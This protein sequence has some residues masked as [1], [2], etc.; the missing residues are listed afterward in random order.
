MSK[1]VPLLII[2]CLPFL[3]LTQGA[4]PKWDID[5]AWGGDQDDYLMDI[6]QE[7][8]DYS[9]VS[10]GY[11][12]SSNNQDVSSGNKGYSDYWIVKSDTSGSIIYQR[13]F[14]ADSVDQLAV[15]VPVGYDAD[16]GY[17]LAGSS[18]SGQNGDKSED[19]KGG[20]DYWVI[21]IDPFG[22]KEWDKTIGG[23]GDDIL[24][25][26][27]IDANGNFILGGYSFSGVSGDK[28][29][30]NR[31]DEDYW[32]VKLDAS[33]NK[34]W[35]LTLGGD[36]SDILSNIT[37]RN[38]KIIVGG[39]SL[40][41]VSGDKS[42]DS[43]GGYDFWL[44]VLDFNGDILMDQTIG[45]NQDDFLEEIR[46]RAHVEGFWISGTT[47]SGST[48]NKNTNQ[49]GN[50]DAWVVVVDTLMN[51]SWD[52]TIGSGNSEVMKDMEIAP[53]G[54]A[55]LAG[56]GSG[57]GGNK[58]SSTNGSEDF[59]ICKLDTAGDF[60]WDKNYGGL[61]GDSIEAIFIKCDR[62]ILAGGF[63]V[64]DIS[65]DKTHANKGGVDYW[66]FELS[67]TTH[68]WFRTSNVC[69]RTP[70]NFFDESDTWPDQWQWDF[71]DPTSANNN[72][73]D[74]HP[75]H[76]YAEPG[77]YNVMMT[78][79]EGCQNDTSITKEVIVYE[80]TVLGNVDLGRDFS[81]CGSDSV[82]LI[83]KGDVP[84]RS[85]YVWS[86]GDSTENAWI[87]YR[88]TYT[89]TVTEGNC[90]ARDSVVVDTCPT[91]AVPNAFS[92]N[93]DDKNEVFKIPGVGFN[94]YELLIY[95]RWGQLIYRSTK[96]EE[97]W[98][99]RTMNGKPCQIDVYVYKLNFQ[100][101]GLTPTQKVGTIALIR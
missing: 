84:L 89:L 96:Q 97:G 48:G 69:A 67:I 44:N 52:K 4:F 95:N 16:Q 71:D 19:T 83:N 29:E 101:L 72:S 43:F 100:G 5:Y 92:P 53:D 64:S 10:A 36:T 13:M 80:N 33:G 37:V 49:Y 35:D 98:D 17:L 28:S 77:V 57:S 90:S 2:G 45:G 14:G 59:W 3:G 82:E 22:N 7:E 99:G 94:V 27:T 75:I 46:P 66:A 24:T 87:K 76:T 60:I 1:I 23:D 39:H 41:G 50:G 88:G 21:K 70:L 38:D 30:A 15:L 42:Q 54:G 79:K 65:G 34:I 31:G 86:T 18:A 55:I 26:A 9:I 73:T 58:G 47:F 51:I 40:S 78:I 11:S 12:F 20:Y 81:L 93:G 68:P 32:I 91:F 6:F 25:S 74:Q 85:T 56:W 63:S 62:G 8:K 61:Q